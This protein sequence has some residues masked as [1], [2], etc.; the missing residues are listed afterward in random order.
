[1]G[2]ELTGNGTVEVQ[3]LSR[4]E[5]RINQIW[6]LHRYTCHLWLRN[7]VKVFYQYAVPVHSQ[8]YSGNHFPKRNELDGL[9]KNKQ[10]RL[11]NLFHQLWSHNCYTVVYS[12]NLISENAFR[13]W[14][15]LWHR[16]L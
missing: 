16:K 14:V 11:Y 4:W 3:Q 12:V 8:Q 10:V 5:V 2:E 6:I 15:L 7:L 1:M 9:N 13:G